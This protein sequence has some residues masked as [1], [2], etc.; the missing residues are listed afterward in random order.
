MNFWDSTLVR[1]RVRAVFGD[2]LEVVLLRGNEPAQVAT[3]EEQIRQATENSQWSFPLE[4]V[5][6]DGRSV[7]EF[8]FV[9]MP[10]SFE[11]ALDH[12][13]DE[14]VWPIERRDPADE[15]L[16]DTKVAAFEGDN[17]ADFKQPLCSARLNYALRGECR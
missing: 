5:S 17:V 14:P 3:H 16:R 15:S 4:R 10:E 2:A 8:E 7:C 13:I 6:H 9:H 11:R 12:F 1:R